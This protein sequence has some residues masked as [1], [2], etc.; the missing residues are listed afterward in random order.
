[1]FRERDSNGI[2]VCQYKQGPPRSRTLRAICPIE[3]RRRRRHPILRGGGASEK[4]GSRKEARAKTAHSADEGGAAED[5]T[6]VY[7]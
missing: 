5:A 4:A 6:S 7:L 3:E 2:A 1:M